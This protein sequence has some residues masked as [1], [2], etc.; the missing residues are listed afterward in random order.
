M[1][2][3]VM[4]SYILENY[5]QINHLPTDYDEKNL[6]NAYMDAKYNFKVHRNSYLRHGEV[7]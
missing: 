3:K 1:T 5:I 6:V 7:E 2:S 4:E